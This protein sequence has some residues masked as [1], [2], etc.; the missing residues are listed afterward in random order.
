MVA[1]SV[2]II[3]TV[4]GNRCR[5]E[6]RPSIVTVRTSKFEVALVKSSNVTL[7]S[8]REASTSGDRVAAENFYQHA[9]HYFRVMNAASE[10]HQ[11]H[12][13]HPTA[14]ADLE[15]EIAEGVGSG[16]TGP[17]RTASSDKPPYS[18]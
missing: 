18:F 10:G 5:T 16:M 3:P 2:I 4:I 13:T 11:N 12:A 6:V 14:P 15:T 7:P 17:A 9:E 1:I 8:P